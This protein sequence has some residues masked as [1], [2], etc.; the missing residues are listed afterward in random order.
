[1]E[2]KTRIAGIIIEDNRLLMLIGKGYKELWTPGGKVNEG[3]TDEECLKRELQEE[4]GV[5]LLE[6]KF[7]KEYHNESFYNPSSPIIERN[8][9]IKIKGEIKPDSEIE[10]IVWFTKDDYQNKKYPMI[11]H[12][13]EELI[14]DLIKEG[15][16]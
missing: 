10:S 6:F 4:L 14:P 3:E 2:T 7:F 13:Q 8:Y 15:I 16:W 12:T 1:M 9:I 11:T 5:E